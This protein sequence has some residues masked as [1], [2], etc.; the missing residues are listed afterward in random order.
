[1]VTARIKPLSVDGKTV[2]VV[3]LPWHFGFKGECAGGP[4]YKHYGANQLT[5]HVG[6][7]NTMIPEYKAFVVDV[8]KVK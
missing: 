2:H 7:A 8:R 4:K 1:M 3:G 6:D 5:P